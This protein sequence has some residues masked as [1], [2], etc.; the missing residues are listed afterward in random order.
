MT[1]EQIEAKKARVAEALRLH[2]EG[3]SMTEISKMMGVRHETVR[4]YLMLSGVHKPKPQDGRSK[5]R[6]S[7]IKRM[8]CGRVRCYALV[9]MLYLDYIPVK[10]IAEIANIGSNAITNQ[11]KR[12]GLG[13]NHQRMRPKVVNE[14][15]NRAKLGESYYAIAKDIGMNP[16]SV[17]TVAIKNGISRGKGG[18]CVARNNAARSSKAAPRRMARVRGAIGER[19]EVVRETRKD[20]FLLRCRECGHEFERFVDLHY[21]TTC[22]E[23]QRR[24]VERREV[25]RRAKSEQEQ[26]RA[27]MQRLVNI[28]AYEHVCPECGARFRSSNS[29]KL[30]CSDRCKNRRKGYSD[31]ETRAKKFGVE[32][33]RSITLSRLIQRDGLECYI[34]GK[35]C[36]TNDKRWGSFGPDYP[37]IDCVVA[38]SNGGTFTWDNVRVACGECNCVRKGSRD[39]AELMAVQQRHPGGMPL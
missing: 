10:E 1:A 19:F 23:C 14:I 18:G 28:L 22:P 32:F 30:Y 37:T 6:S 21:P 11:M 39:V 13:R 16:A 24:E 5:I 7:K 15:V 9:R 27:L 2:D 29:Q 4:R 31:H 20:W 17:S 36:N 35:E 38:M 26:K 34:C 25:E 8:P 12:E 33:D 3:L